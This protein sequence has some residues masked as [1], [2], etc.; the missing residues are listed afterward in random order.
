MWSRFKDGRP[1]TRA[2]IAFC[3]DMVPLAV[4]RA[5][6][7]L[8]AGTSLDN[9]LRFGHI[10]ETEW[11]LLEMQG[12]GDGRQPRGHGALQ[13]ALPAR[14]HGKVDARHDLVAGQHAANRY[15]GTGEVGQV[16]D[17]ARDDDIGPARRNAAHDAAHHVGRHRRERDIDVRAGAAQGLFDSG[18]NFQ[19]EL[20]KDRPGVFEARGRPIGAV[21]G[22][23]RLHLLLADAIDLG[24]FGHEY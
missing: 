16:V 21:A 1:M 7:K 18:R 22:P 8:G 17:R 4:A 12:K 3:A 23:P 24:R 19:V 2:G 9:S 10:T 11:V 6:G 13:A 15:G 20:G 14:D 5:A